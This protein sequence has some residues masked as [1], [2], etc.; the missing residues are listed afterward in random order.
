MPILRLSNKEY[1]VTLLD[2]NNNPF[3]LT[4]EKEKTTLD[5]ILSNISKTIDNKTDIETI[6]AIL[7]KHLKNTKIKFKDIRIR[8]I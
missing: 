1:N 5:N 3:F 6:R 8:E 4:K 7:Y 2:K